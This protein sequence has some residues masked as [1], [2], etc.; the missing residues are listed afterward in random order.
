VFEDE[1]LRARGFFEAV[2]HAVA[3]TWEM[4]APH[5]RM[6]ETPAHVRIPPPSFAEHNTWVFRDLLGLSEEEI[7]ALKAE[8]VTGDVPDWSVHE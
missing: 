7:A 6:S 4:E 8:G 2:S 1:H 5:W 3:G